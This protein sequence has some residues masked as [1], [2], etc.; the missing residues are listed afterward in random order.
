MVSR[1]TL[2]KGFGGAVGAAALPAALVGCGGDDDAAP[3]AGGGGGAKEVGTVTI[4]S[5][6]SDPVPKAS[7]EKVFAGF[8]TET[9][10]DVKV[11][12]VDHNT[13]QEQINSYLQGRPDDAFMWFAGYRM[14]FFAQ[15]GLATDI[16][17]VWGKIGSQLLRRAQERVDRAWTASSTS[18]RSTTTRGRSSTARACSRRRATRS[19]RRSTTSRRSATKMK[20]RRAVADRA[21]PT[22]TA[23]RR[24][25]PST[26]STC[27]STATTS[28]CSS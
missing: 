25:G 5:N 1:R 27:A 14:Q 9:G 7:Y 8:K 3:S 24:W 22:R 12:T 20:K 21:S 13:F 23:G 19:R 2:L 17:D 15:R 10:G 18:S 6:A 11:N 4:G 28:T 26:S 16:S